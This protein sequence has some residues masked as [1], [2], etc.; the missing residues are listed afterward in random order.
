MEKLAYSVSELAELLSIG[1]S[2]AYKLVA[3]ESFYPAIRIGDRSIRIDAL[4]LHQW[5]G[6]QTQGGREVM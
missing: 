3:Q 5:L 6:E 2:A 1:R 4:A